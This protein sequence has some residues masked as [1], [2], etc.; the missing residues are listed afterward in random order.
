MLN[1]TILVL[2]QFTFHFSQNNNYN[3]LVTLFPYFL[4]RILTIYLNFLLTKL[5]PILTDSTFAEHDSQVFNSFPS[6]SSQNNNY[7]ELIMFF[8]CSHSPQ[9]PGEAV[10]EWLACGSGEVKVPG[11]SPTAAVDFPSLLRSRRPPTCCLKEQKESDFIVKSEKSPN[12]EWFINNK[13]TIGSLIIVI[14]R[15]LVKAAI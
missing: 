6:A 14:V 7:K 11:S 1:T 12:K 15:M 10:A 3:E 9:W 2:Q 8:M 4:A 5:E 13:L